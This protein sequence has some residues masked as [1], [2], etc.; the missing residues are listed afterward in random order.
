MITIR[1]I[2]NSDWTGIMEIQREAYPEFL[3]E[4]YEALASKVAVSPDTC[5]AA[6]EN[7]IVLGY[8]ITLPCRKGIP[9]GINTTKDEYVESEELHIHDMAVRKSARGK[10]IGELLEKHMRE[11]LPVEKYKIISLVAVEGADAYWS[12]LDYKE[13]VCSKS[14]EPY[15]ESAKYMIKGL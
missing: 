2:K 3:A 13:T 14:L 5:Y 10:K 15:G 1:N 6:I 7:D 9:P 11:N 8:I 4:T 12:M